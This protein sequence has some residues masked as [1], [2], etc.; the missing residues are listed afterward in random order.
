MATKTDYKK[1]SYEIIGDMCVIHTRK[2][3][4]L[5]SFLYYQIEYI[6]ERLKKQGQ[7][8]ITCVVFENEPNILYTVASLKGRYDWNEL[9]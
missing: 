9:K 7:D 5:P 1:V 4:L 8:L 2:V 3:D 6:N